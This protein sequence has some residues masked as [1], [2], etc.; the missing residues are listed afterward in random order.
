MSDEPLY[1]EMAIEVAPIRDHP[2]E[3]FFGKGIANSGVIVCNAYIYM[4]NLHLRRYHNHPIQEC[5][6]STMKPPAEQALS[7]CFFLLTPSIFP[8]SPD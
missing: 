3:A 2:L 1:I 7:S 5:H 4:P 8:K 6:H